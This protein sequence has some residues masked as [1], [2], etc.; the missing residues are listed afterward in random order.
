M[1]SE[2]LGFSSIAISQLLAFPLERPPKPTQ[3]CSGLCQKPNPKLPSPSGA[4]PL[5][6]N[7]AAAPVLPQ[8]L[9]RDHPTLFFAHQYIAILGHLISIS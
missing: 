5:L 4:Q 7:T 1:S 3:K 9:T 2:A 6:L 8:N